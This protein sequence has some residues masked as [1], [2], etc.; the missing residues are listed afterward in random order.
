MTSEPAGLP[1]RADSGFSS[2]G[3]APGMGLVGRYELLR[4]LG[5]GGMAEVHLARAS[6]LEGF[7]KLV[8]LKRILPHLSADPHFIK[9]FMDE[10]RLSALLEHPNDFQLFDNGVDDEQYFFTMEFV[11]GENLQTLTKILARRGKPLPYP[12]AIAIA[13]GA[14]AGLHYAHERVGWDGQPLGIVHRDVSPTNVMVTYDGCVKVADFG[15]AKVTSR[16]DVTRAGMRKG[17][18]PY[19]SPEQCRAEKLDRRSDVFALGIVLW[20]CSTGCRLFDGDNEFGVMNRI[21]SGDI[22]LPS[23]RRAD[24]PKDLERIVMRALSVDPRR[25][26]A[27]AHQVQQELQALARERKLDASPS[28][29]AEFMHRMFQPQPFPWGALHGGGVMGAAASLATEIGVHDLASQSG[30]GTP[31]G[32]PDVTPQT[33]GGSWNGMR[34]HHSTIASVASVKEVQRQSQLRGIAMGLGVAAALAVA[35]VG[36][37]WIAR[38]GDEGT[39]AADSEAAPSPGDAAVAPASPSSAVPG[40][41]PLDA[42]PTPPQDEAAAPGQGE[43]SAAD[44]E[45]PPDEVLVVIEEEAPPAEPGK[46]SGSSRRSKGASQTSAKPRPSSSKKHTDGEAKKTKDQDGGSKKPDLDAFFPQ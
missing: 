43:A 23:T 10:A 35:G 40:Q 27:T 41:P 11:Y 38:S 18:V 34:T 15:I 29:L 28:A 45:V 4:R 3:Q 12:L 22:P 36:G 31:S 19:M 37:I 6:G 9:M 7:E 30:A 39:A 44:E 42:A 1:H 25:R 16:T 26:Y 14:A 5:S 33:G 17:K 32:L 2:S 20:E 21:V 13:I 8:V 46:S 24:Y